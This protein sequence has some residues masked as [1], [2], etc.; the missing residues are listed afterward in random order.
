MKSV[1]R[2]HRPSFLRPVWDLRQDATLVLTGALTVLQATSFG[3]PGRRRPSDA[4]S[5]DRVKRRTDALPR[6]SLLELC[7]AKGRFRRW[8]STVELLLVGAALGLTG[9]VWAS[10]ARFARRFNAALNS[11]ADRE[12]SRERSTRKASP[13]DAPNAG[14]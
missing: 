14:S 10:R 13:L 2:Q 12:I 5:A 11:Y 3:G 4:I 9:V 1:G 8:E 6:V 7:G